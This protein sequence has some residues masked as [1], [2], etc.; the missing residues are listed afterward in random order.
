MS[1]TDAGLRSLW[2]RLTRLLALVRDDDTHIG[3][4]LG[5]G[6]AEIFVTVD[7]QPYRIEISPVTDAE[8]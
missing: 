7:G 8:I 2:D 4:G 1:G 6:A 3:A 5:D